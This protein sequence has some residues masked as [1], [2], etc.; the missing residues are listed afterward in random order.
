MNANTA[1]APLIKGRQRYAY[2]TKPSWTGKTIW[3][4]NSKTRNF[5]RNN[6]FLREILINDQVQSEFPHLFE[7]I[8][9]ATKFCHLFANLPTAFHFAPSD[10]QW[11]KNSIIRPSAFQSEES[12]RIPHSAFQSPGITCILSWGS[13]YAHHRTT[14]YETKYLKLFC[15]S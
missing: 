13:F 7:N 8:R 9:T 15:Y 10:W 4:L 2:T 3:I 1:H 14:F 12:F 6:T 5:E 11:A